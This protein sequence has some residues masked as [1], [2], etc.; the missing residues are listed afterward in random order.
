MR[1]TLNVFYALLVIVLIGAGGCTTTGQEGATESDVDSGLSAGDRVWVAKTFTG[2]E[3]CNPDSSY[4]PPD[5]EVQLE[6]AGI[7]VYDTQVQNHPVCAACTCP[8][9]SAT[10]FAAIDE[11]DVDAAAE[12]GFQ[13]KDPPAG[14]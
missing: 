11:T 14:E 7:A 13:L 12:I 5:I 1:R 3:Q 9:Y 8:D 6:E 4:T 2:G 10:H